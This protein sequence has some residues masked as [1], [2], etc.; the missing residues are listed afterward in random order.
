MTKF[1]I[2][3]EVF[4]V[5]RWHEEIIEVPDSEWAAMTPAEREQRM[6]DAFEEQRNE[7]ANGGYE[8]IE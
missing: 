4:S 1:K 6:A 2:W 3:T 5:Q 8:V 7:I